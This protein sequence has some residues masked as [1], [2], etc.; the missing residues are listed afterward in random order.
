M[1]AGNNER[2]FGHV[3]LKS[4]TRSRQEIDD[5]VNAVSNRITTLVNNNTLQDL[6]PRTIWCENN[7]CSTEATSVNARGAFRVQENGNLHLL[8]KSS[9]DGVMQFAVESDDNNWRL[10]THNAQGGWS[11]R[12]PIDVRRN[13]DNGARDQVTLTGN[14]NLNGTVTSGINLSDGYRIEVRNVNG[15]PRLCM[16]R[17]GRVLTAFHDGQDVMQVYPTNNTG[18]YVY[19]NAQNNTGFHDGTPNGGPYVRYGQEL[20]IQGAGGTSNGWV[21]RGFLSLWGNDTADRNDAFTRVR[22]V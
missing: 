6:R 17:N 8:S 20:Q 12:Y 5:A 15:Q 9:R 14:L 16:T 4:E 21:N 22:I 1:S 2:W 3:Y 7:T 11:G 10:V 13:V 19:V 18:A